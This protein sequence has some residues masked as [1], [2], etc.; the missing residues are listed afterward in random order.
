MFISIVQRINESGIIM[1]SMAKKKKKKKK[2]R[3]CL[4]TQC[5]YM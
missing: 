4:E 2:S 1:I 5:S 3:K